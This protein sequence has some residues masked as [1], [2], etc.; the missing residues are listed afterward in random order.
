MYDRTKSIGASDAVMIYEGN[1]PELYDRKTA[2]DYA[3]RPL[4]AEIGKELEDLNRRW[5]ERETGIRVHYNEL[6][7]DTPLFDL[8]HTWRKY[9]PDGLIRKVETDKTPP[10]LISTAIFEAKAVNPYWKPSNLLRKYMPQLQH[11]MRVARTNLAYFSVI[12]LNIKWEF[13]EVPYDPAYDL[14]LF[15]MEIAFLWYLTEGVRP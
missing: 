13:T 11:G 1:W 12:Y 7:T 10:N 5:F 6:W 3:Q 8:H 14:A 2:T 4:A 9:S 15:E